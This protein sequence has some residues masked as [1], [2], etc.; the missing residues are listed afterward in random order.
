MATLLRWGL[1]AE[2]DITATPAGR[3]LPFSKFCM[4]PSLPL[5]DF[6]LEAGPGPP[7]PANSSGLCQN[8]S[9]ITTRNAAPSGSSTGGN[10]GG[11][12]SGATGGV[13]AMTVDPTGVLWAILGNQNIVRIAPDGSSK[14]FQFPPKTSKPPSAALAAFEFDDGYGH[15]YQLLTR[16][17]YGVYNYVGAILRNKPLDIDNLQ[18]DNEKYRGIVRIVFSDGDCFAAVGYRNM[19]YCVPT[20]ANNTKKLFALLHQLQQLNTAPSN[21]PTTLTIVPG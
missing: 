15:H 4:D 5:P 13:T 20:D 6:A 1:T 17:T 3:A 9:W 12:N 10:S 2:I 14:E 11:E 7:R 18:P 16:S 21:T 8:A 19:Q